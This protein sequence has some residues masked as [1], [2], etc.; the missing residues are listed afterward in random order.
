MAMLVLTHEGLTIQTIT[1]G[2]PRLTIGRHAD[3]D[4][5]LDDKLASKTHAVVEAQPHPDTKDRTDYFIEDLNSTN[6]TVVNGEP[7][8]RH[9][10]RHADTIRIGKHVF[11]F[12]DESPQQGDKTTKLHKSWLRG[13]YYT[14]E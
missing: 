13:V 10:L 12:I 5:Y 7:I 4:I 2:Q 11:K 14:K 8:T 3:C 6:H 9:Q 1:L